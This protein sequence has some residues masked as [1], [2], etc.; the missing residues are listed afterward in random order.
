MFSDDFRLCRIL[1]EPCEV[2]ME[3]LKAVFVASTLLYVL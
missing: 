1:K 3:L 2:I